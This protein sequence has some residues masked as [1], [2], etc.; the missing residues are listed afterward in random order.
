MIFTEIDVP[1][2]SQFEPSQPTFRIAQSSER[3]TIDGSETPKADFVK[4]RSMTLL[5][6][7]SVL[8]LT[9]WFSTT[10]VVP[11]L[12]LEYGLDGAR[13]ALLTSAI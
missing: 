4:F 7:A 9:L 6:G 11:S 2:R 12:V 13:A 3:V 10:A 1:A 8:S 5:V